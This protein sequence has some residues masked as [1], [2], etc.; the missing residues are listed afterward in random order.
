MCPLFLRIGPI[1]IYWYGVMMALGCLAG[2]LSLARLGRREGRDLS[3]ISDVLFWI[4]VAGILGAR[5]TYLAANYRY[6][7]AHPAEVWRID[8]GGLVYYG[9]FAASVVAVF[10]FARA[11]QVDTR[12]LFDFLA[13]SVPLAHAFGRVGCFLNGC[14]HGTVSGLFCLGVRFPYNSLPWH[15]QLDLREKMVPR[16]SSTGL[17]G[18]HDSM[19][20]P[21]HP[22]QL[23]EA[24][25]NLALYALLVWGYRRWRRAG[26]TASVYL[27]LYGIG[28]LLL[29]VLR[30]DERLPAWGPLNIAQTVSLCS[31]IAGIAWMVWGRS[32]LVTTASAKGQPETGRLRKVSAT[33]GKHENRCSS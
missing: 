21:I 23:Y 1:R 27:V 5:L 8:R 33:G 7:M 26:T 28:R 22:V 4:L 30:G 6:Y 31:V 12:R 2:F 16:I 14:C 10:L 18:A 15:R 13:T 20:M 24:A 25:F 3:F 9:G 29:E 11:R 17:L 19:A 32:P